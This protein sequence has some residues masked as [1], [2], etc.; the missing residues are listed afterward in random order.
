VNHADKAALRRIHTEGV[1][2]FGYLTRSASQAITAIE[3]MARAMD[4]LAGPHRAKWARKRVPLYWRK[5]GVR[6]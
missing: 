3:D 6:K 1:D 5:G 4:K 2:A